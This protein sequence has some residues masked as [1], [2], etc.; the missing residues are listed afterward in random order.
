MV[1][2]VLRHDPL[3]AAVLEDPLP[4]EETPEYAAFQLAAADAAPPSRAF[5]DEFDARARRPRVAARR[6]EGR[7]TRRSSR[8][9]CAR[10]SAC[11]ARALRRRRD[12]LVLDPAQN[13]ILGETLTLTTL[14]KLSRA[15][16]H[17]HYTFRKKLSH[18]ADW[19][20]Q[21]HRMTPASRPV[22]AA[23]LSD[24]PDYV[25]PML[26]ADGPRR[27]TSTGDTMEETWRAIGELRSRGVSD[28]FAAYLLPERGRDPLHGVG[29]PAP[30]APQVRDA[31][32]LQRAGGDLAR[33][34]RR[35]AADP[36][37]QPAHR[38]VAP[39]AL[40]AAPP[41]RRSARVCPEGERYCGVV[42]WK[43]QPEEY[44]RAAL[45]LTQAPPRAG[46]RLS[47]KSTEG[48]MRIG[49]SLRVLTPGL[50]LAVLSL[51]STSLA[52]T[53]VPLWRQTFRPSAS[54]TIS[55]PPIAARELVDGTV[56]VVTE[57]GAV[58]RF[59]HDGNEVSSVQL[60]LGKPVPKF[61]APTARR[62]GAAGGRR[63]ASAGRR[64]RRVR[65]RRLQPPDPA[66]AS[67][68]RRR[69]SSR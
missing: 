53:A 45:T 10:C 11:R 12:P 4:L 30:P 36:R 23:Y 21:R 8:R 47:D 24:E 48:S 66:R 15:L 20:D 57:Q 7:T 39:A 34:A 29:R 67:W 32:L 14:D 26:V 31:P 50:L 56:M 55:P 13:R 60:P 1:A 68:T 42:V 16:F 51:P 43:Q 35:G 59:D 28:E 58:V 18:T 2:E 65:H 49:R 40:H 17:A 41:R 62:A 52:Q 38:P 64:D 6:L 61:R 3:F 9:P 63:T 54:G 27:T 37:G 46:M 33:V 22:L 69:T 19:Q 44:V 5:R 25:V